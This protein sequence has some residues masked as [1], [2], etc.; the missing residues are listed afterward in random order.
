MTIRAGSRSREKLRLGHADGAADRQHVVNLRRVHL[1]DGLVA[2]ELVG[3]AH[4]HLGKERRPRGRRGRDGAAR[5]ESSRDLLCVRCER[6][7]V[8]VSRRTWKQ[9]LRHEAS[10]CLL[11]PLKMCFVP[12]VPSFVRQTPNLPPF[13]ATKCLSIPSGGQAGG[14]DGGVGGGGGIPGGAGGSGGVGGGGLG[15]AICANAASTRY[16]FMAADI[17]AQRIGAVRQ[18]GCSQPCY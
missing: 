17:G 12:L 1:A 18:P 15:P 8:C 3:D 9:L 14:G 13:T 7:S 4:V 16:E 5:A 2:A 10:V 6:V 11:V